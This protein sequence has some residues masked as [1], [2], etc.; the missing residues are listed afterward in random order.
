MSF[1]SSSTFYQ[2]LDTT[3]HPKTPLLQQRGAA[4]SLQSWTSSPWGRAVP[5]PPPLLRPLRSRLSSPPS[6]PPSLPPP[7]P[8]PPSLPPPLTPPTPLTPPPQSLQPPRLWISLVVKVL[9][10]SLCIS[11]HYG[12][13]KVALDD[14][15]DE[16]INL[17]DFLSLH[18]PWYLPLSYSL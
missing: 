18:F 1:P 3:R 7:P 6:L 10:L 11:L 13:E 12:E 15:D 4:T 8:P 16:E 14:D 2:P 17:R 5:A 9:S